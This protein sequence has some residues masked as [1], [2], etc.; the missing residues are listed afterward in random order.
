MRV[1]EQSLAPAM[2]AAPEAL[3]L[4]DGFSCHMQVRQLDPGRRS[5]HL[6]ELLDPGTSAATRGRVAA[7]RPSDEP[8][9]DSRRRETETDDISSP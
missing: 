9:P 3:I 5:S 6:A 7:E 1:A 8:L 2:R 4:T